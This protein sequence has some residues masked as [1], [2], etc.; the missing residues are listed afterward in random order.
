MNL[1][2]YSFLLSIFLVSCGGK[3]PAIEDAKKIVEQNPSFFDT[4]ISEKPVNPSSP[5]AKNI[6]K[7][8]L[9]YESYHNCQI[10]ETLFIGL[11][12]GAT[13]N[14]VETILDKTIVSRKWQGETF[15]RFLVKHIDNKDL[16]HL[17]NHTTGIV[18]S[19]RLHNS[20]FI[21][22]TGMIYIQAKYFYYEGLNLGADKTPDFLYEVKNPRTK[23]YTRQQDDKKMV[24]YMSYDHFRSKDYELST[25]SKNFDQMQIS[26][27]RVLYHELSHAA[28]YFAH[29]LRNTLD[30]ELDSTFHDLLDFNEENKN[31]ISLKLFDPELTPPNQMLFAMEKCTLEGISPLEEYSEC[32][33]NIEDIFSE[34]KNTDKVSTYGFFTER[35]HLATLN[36][37]L[38]M[39]K[40]HKFI[41]S[42][43][44]LKTST[45]NDTNTRGND[46]LL[47]KT[48]SL[49]VT[50]PLPFE[51]V[52]KV[53]KEVFDSSI[54]KE[55]IKGMNSFEASNIKFWELKSNVDSELINQFL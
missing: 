2:I 10:E 48:I 11:E 34:Y 39:L 46:K 45:F 23:N 17:F 47:E 13:T 53:Y 40:N 1:Y 44:F 29:N 36:T 35:E 21:S 51:S 15:K 12:S 41:V 50:D 52:S 28:D 14:K 18:I 26:L 32:Q 5:F 22:V 16:M 9:K 30:F 25:K 33:F 38:L 24:N 49:K 31:I 7:C 37:H 42:T 43:A 27:I 55:I 4:E 8:A 54:D 3:N 20:F 6:I 19:H